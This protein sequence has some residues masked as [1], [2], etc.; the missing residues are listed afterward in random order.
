MRGADLAQLIVKLFY[1]GSDYFRGL[2][3]FC[4]VKFCGG[5]CKGIPKVGKGLVLKYPPHQGYVIGRSCEIGP[6]CFFDIPPGGRIVIGDNVKLT[7]GVIISAAQEVMIGDNSLIAEW[8]S[9]RDSQHNYKDSS[10]IREQGLNV[11][12]VRVGSDVWVGRAAAVLM[13]SVLED[14]CIVGAHSIVKQ[15][16][17]EGGTV[18]VG[19]P[20]KKIGV[21]NG[22]GHE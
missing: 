10:L 16:V 1:R 21:R 13:G 3:L 11:G 12:C 7:A 19:V 6:F 8:S 5:T 4:T 9:L 22:L 20:I 14:G 15:Q 2:W 18:Y 17:L